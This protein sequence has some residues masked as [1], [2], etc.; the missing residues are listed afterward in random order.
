MVKQ[1]GLQVCEV[2]NVLNWKG[3]NIGDL[4]DINLAISD[5]VTT[6]RS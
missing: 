5:N 4:P 2:I 6:R 1:Q 3:H